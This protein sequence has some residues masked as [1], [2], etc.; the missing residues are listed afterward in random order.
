[1]G[2]VAHKHIAEVVDFRELSKQVGVGLLQFLKLGLDLRDVLLDELF[3]AFQTLCLVILR[4]VI[5][6]FVVLTLLF[7]LDLWQ[8]IPK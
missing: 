6:I 5:G 2:I 7:P 3:V 1:M 8:T 4:E